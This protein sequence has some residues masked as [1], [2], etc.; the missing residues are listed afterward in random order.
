MGNGEIFGATIRARIAASGDS[1]VVRSKTASESDP[2]GYNNRGWTEAH[3]YKTCSIV[4]TK[5][6]DLLRGTA[7]RD[8]ICGLGGD[9]VITGGARNDALLGGRGDDVLHGGR[10]SD[11]VRGDAGSDVLNGGPRRDICLPGPGTGLRRSCEL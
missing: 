8:F 7:R 3:A 9:D 1:I 2:Y 11:L 5:G 6:P 4:G 10:G